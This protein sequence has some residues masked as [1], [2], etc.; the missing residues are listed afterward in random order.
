MA[1]KT[2]EPKNPI[3]VIERMLKLLDVLAAHPEPLG[4]KQ[5]AQYTSLHPSTAHRI[6]AAMAGD[7][8]V[9]R[10]EPA[11]YRLGMRL[12]ELSNIVR[13]RIS[14]RELALP[15]M[16][17]LH[18]QTGETVNLSV[19]HDDEIVYVERTSSGRSAMRIIHAIGARAPLHVTAA[20]KLFLL[21]D[22]YARLRD[23][24]RRTG[25]AAHTKNSLS[26]VQV[27]ERDLDRTQRQ[28]FA[29]DNEEAEI[30]VGRNVPFIASRATSSSNLD[31]L[32]ATIERYDVGITLRMRPQITADDFVRLTLFEEVSD[33]DPIAAVGDPNL[34]GPT[35]TV[36]SA[37]TVIAARDAQTVVIGGLL[38]DA[39]RNM[40]RSVPYLGDIPVLGRLFRRDSNRRL[41]T[42]LLVFLTPHII[43]SDTDMADASERERT[44][45]PRALRELPVLRAPSWNVPP[46]PPS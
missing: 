40:E 37:T 34:V 44:R 5:I 39:I 26:S 16:R 41:K 17:E 1:T 42:N 6:L 31:N 35:T 33:I 8:L 32:F 10:I 28:G 7:R 14:V 22:G 24:A 3:Q 46:P 20:G 43:G 30:V 15:V 13:S 45:L 23:Y 36:R 9:D 38:S 29:T 18:A 21:E 12:L 4:L 19:R 2:G 25:L 27:L 11:S